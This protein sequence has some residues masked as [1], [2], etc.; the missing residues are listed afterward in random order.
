MDTLLNDFGDFSFWLV[1]ENNLTKISRFIFRVNQEFHLKSNILNY[2]DLLKTIEA[3]NENYSSSCFYAIKN[4]KNEIIGSIKAQKWNGIT[5]LPLEEDFNLNINDI[6]NQISYIPSE[7]WHIGRFAID[8]KKINAD[9]KLRKYR[10]TFL[11]LLLVNAFQ[12]I[13]SKPKNIAIAECDRK[14]FEKLKLLQINS[15][16]LGASKM[17]LGSETLPIINTAQGVNKFVDANKKLCYVNNNK[18]LHSA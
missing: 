18:D 8:Q 17:Y 16:A 13:N 12:H 4:R 6:L 11:K 1:A 14:L 15:T 5:K 10:L 7:I 9:A 2:N 3:D